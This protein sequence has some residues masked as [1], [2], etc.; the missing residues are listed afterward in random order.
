MKQRKLDWKPRFDDRSRLY[1]ISDIVNV[2]ETK[3]MSVLW[4]EGTV[5]DQ[6]SEGACVGFGWA[7]EVLAQPVAPPIQPSETQG[8]KDA[9]GYYNRAKQLDQWPGENYEGTSVLAGARVMKELGFIES[10]RWCFSIEELRAA[11]ISEG[12]VVIGI[13]WYESMYYTD[14]NGK[15]LILG[16]EVG[17]HCLVITGYISNM[18]I[19]GVEQ[20]VFRWRNSW[21]NDYGVNGSAFIT[22]KDLENLVRHNA[23]MCV[24]MGRRIP[25]SEPKLTNSN[26]CSRLFERFLN[27]FHN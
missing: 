11:V 15:V 18:I 14:H 17:G 22:Y 4:N 27:K 9:L 23:E 5:L 3:G 1:G 7:G 6:G 16:K 20:E 2:E 10:Y 8:N 24:P 12:P 26:I 13:P 25:S 21:G 19:D